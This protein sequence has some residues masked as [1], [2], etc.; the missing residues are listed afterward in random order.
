MSRFE[1]TFALGTLTFLY[2]L[3]IDKN[4]GMRS[5][6]AILLAL[7]AIISITSNAA[8]TEQVDKAVKDIIATY[9]DSKGIETVSVAK[10]NGLEIVK[11][12]LKKHFGKEFMRGVTSITVLS[13]GGATEAICNSIRKDLDTIAAI[14][15]EFD[16]SGNKDFSQND[17]MRCFAQ[18]TES[19]TLSDFVVA[20]EKDQHKMVVYMA[21]EIK[22][23]E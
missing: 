12:M 14:L 10:G 16:V 22:V 18:R 8:T 5:F 2:Y 20:L 21:G 15:E 6:R 19:G 13:Y 3:C 7:F 11:M 23:E 4:M 1:H 9:K 17:Y